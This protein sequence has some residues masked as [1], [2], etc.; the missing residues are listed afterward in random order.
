M[1]A[2]NRPGPIGAKPLPG[3]TGPHPQ[4]LSMA[5]IF[6]ATPSLPSTFSLP[7]I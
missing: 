3:P 4:S 7:V 5:L 6:I 2:V 1:A